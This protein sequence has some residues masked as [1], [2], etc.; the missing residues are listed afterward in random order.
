MWHLNEVFLKI[1]G[2]QVYLLR[3]VDQEGEVRDIPVQKRR[4]ANAAKRFFRKLLKGLCFVPRVIV[5]D[6]LA[7]YRVAHAGGM[8]HVQHLRGRRLNNRAVNSHQPTREREHRMRRFKSIRHAQRFLSV[9]GTLANH[10]RAGRHQLVACS[11]RTP[12]QHQF[13]T[14]KEVTGSPALAAQTTASRP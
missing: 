14:W 5:T 10:F 2:E 6:K 11:Y 7:S 12:M 1:N 3:A 13:A 4:N 8:P 9:H